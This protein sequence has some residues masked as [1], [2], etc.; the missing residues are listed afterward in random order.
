[1]EQQPAAL[2]AAAAALGAAAAA[3]G[4]AAT[5]A[6]RLRAAGTRAGPSARWL[7]G[8]RAAAAA[9]L[10]PHLGAA[11]AFRGRAGARRRAGGDAAGPP[12]AAAA[13]AARP[14]AGAARLAAGEPERAATC[15][16][17]WGHESHG[18]A[19]EE[20]VARGACALL[21]LTVRKL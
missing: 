3:L 5:R 9:G 12:A 10:R 19:P 13:A 21:V 2:E 20:S 8:A 15:A 7:A 6:P 17:M 11:T 14:A 4:A 1:M 16:G 18:R